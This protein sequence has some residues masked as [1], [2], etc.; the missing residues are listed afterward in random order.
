MSRDKT[1]RNRCSYDMIPCQAK[2]GSTRTRTSMRTTAGS[3]TSFTPAPVPYVFD[4][5]RVICE[6]MYTCTVAERYRDDSYACY[7]ADTLD[8]ARSPP[9]GAAAPGGGG[10]RRHASALTCTF[11]RSAHCLSAQKLIPMVL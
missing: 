8:D 9:S 4:F 6:N 2:S 1:R 3:R 11:V 10:A 5:G 7:D